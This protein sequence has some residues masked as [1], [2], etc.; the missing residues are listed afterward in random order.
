M[1][2]EFTGAGTSSDAIVL[3]YRGGDRIY[4]WNHI[5]NKWDDAILGSSMTLENNLCSFDASQSSVIGSGVF[6][7]INYY[8]IPKI[9]LIEDPLKSDKRLWLR[10]RDSYGNAPRA[11]EIGTWSITP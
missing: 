1:I 9:A 3:E 2:K 5:E 7:T 6:V 8:V 11:E 4:M 10:L